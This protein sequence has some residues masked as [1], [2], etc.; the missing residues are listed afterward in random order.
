MKKIL[1]IG[2]GLSASTLIEYLLN[3][4]TEY[5]WK[6][7]LGDISVDTAKDKIDGHPNG[8]AFKFDIFDEQQALDEIAAADI[9][10]SMLPA[11]M[12]YHV[13]KKCVDLKKNMVTA[14]YVSPEIRALDDEAKKAGVA[15]LN[16][17]GVDPGID[18]MSAMKVIDE[19]KL[20]GGELVSFKSST[21]G[22]VAPESDNNIWHYKLTWNPRSAVTSGQGNAQ[23]IQNGQYKYIPYN[24]LF[25]RVEK[26]T[27]LDVGEFEIYANRDSL[28]YRDAYGLEGIPTIFR[29]TMRRP[30]YCEAWNVFVQLGMTDDSYAIEDSENMT[31]RQFINT[32]LPYDPVTKVEE[33]LCNYLNICRNSDIMQKLEWL[34]IFENKAVGLSKATPAQILQKLLVEK[35]TLDETDKDMIVMQ[36]K[37]DFKLNDELR[38]ITSST[39]VIGQDTLHSAMSITVGTPVGIA[40]KLL[41]TEKLKLTGV[42]IPTKKEMYEPILEELK[43]FGIEFV[44]EE[45]VL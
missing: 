15:I 39:V 22:L 30:G 9:V 29:G 1:I 24:Q 12:H 33:K 19:I 4:S 37:F 25:T 20:R 27:V 10:V 26:T 2:A 28:K 13:A 8:E 21:G 43:P 40:V 7:R 38:R 35:W 41:L 6:I 17:L 14:S 3:N 32:Y 18:H 44:E 45:E 11:H 36:H 5:S 23:F 34:G 16:E 31:W 42:H